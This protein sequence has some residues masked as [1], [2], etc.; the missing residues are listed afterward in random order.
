[1]AKQNLVQQLFVVRIVFRC[2]ELYCS[3]LL[4]L[5]FQMQGILLLFGALKQLWIGIVPFWENCSGN[6]SPPFPHMQQWPA[7]VTPYVLDEA[8]S[9]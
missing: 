1:M 4:K 7:L 2:H 6:Q 5:V 3:V 8:A 9:P